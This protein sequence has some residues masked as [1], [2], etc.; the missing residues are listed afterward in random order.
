MLTKLLI[1]VALSTASLLSVAEPLV[2]QPQTKLPVPAVAEKCKE[3]CVILDGADLSQ[4]KQ[5]IE[6]LA[7][8]AFEA[9]KAHE[10]K[11]I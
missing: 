2:V 11:T 8:Q 9:G 3:G 10:K 6:D 1:A 7:R 4:L 5:F